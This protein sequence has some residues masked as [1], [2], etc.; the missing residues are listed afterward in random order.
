MRRVLHL[1][2]VAAFAAFFVPTDARPYPVR[3]WDKADALEPVASL[4]AGI[5]IDVV[6]YEPGADGDPLLDDSWGYVYLFWP[7]EHMSKDVCDGAYAIGHGGGAPEWQQAVGALVL[8]HESFH[9]KQS[10]SWAQRASEAQTECRAIKRFRQTVL[11]LGGSVALAD[12]LLPY[13]L[14]VHYRLARL[15]D[16]YWHE[17]CKV[18]WYWGDD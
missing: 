6:C 16:E 5:E 17:P 8:A 11:D 4:I 12:R 7:Q 14:A 2:L 1:V 3:L 13:A 10:L 18:P 15:V 9:L